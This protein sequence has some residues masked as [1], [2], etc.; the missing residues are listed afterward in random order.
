M[1]HDEMSPAERDLRTVALNSNSQ[2][3]ALTSVLAALERASPPK[4]KPSGFANGGEF[5]AAIRRQKVDHFEDPRLAI[6]NAA[7]TWAG[8]NVPVDGGFACPDE[9]IPDV[10]LPVT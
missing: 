2:I 3:R 1:P 6:L 7:T 4:P 5:L 10:L 9:F 8:E